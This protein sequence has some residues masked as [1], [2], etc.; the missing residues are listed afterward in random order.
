MKE[1]KYSFDSEAEQ[2][3]HVKA[4]SISSKF[5]NSVMFYKD[6]FAKSLFII[7]A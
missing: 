1:V 4:N 5:T 6:T 3:V 7:V 2:K